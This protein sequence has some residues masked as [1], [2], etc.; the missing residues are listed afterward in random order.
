MER[1]VGAHP[2][3]QITNATTSEAAGISFA[4]QIVRDGDVRY[5]LRLPPV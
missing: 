3:A 5:R 2:A 1:Y 4:L